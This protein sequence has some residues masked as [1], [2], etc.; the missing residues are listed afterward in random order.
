MPFETSVFDLP[1][2]VRAIRMTLT[3]IFSGEDATAFMRRIDPG[4]DLAGLPCLTL[5]KDLES[6]SSEARAAISRAANMGELELWSAVVVSNPMIRVAINFIT[7]LQ[8]AKRT[9]LLATEEEAIRW[10][11]AR[12]REELAA[13]AGKAT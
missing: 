3:G 2:G 10:L 6:I 11:D 4:G 12:M 5:T 8:N 1:C 13:K 7:R 9:K